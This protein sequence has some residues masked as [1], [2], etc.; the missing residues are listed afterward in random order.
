MLMPESASGSSS[1][2]DSH[3]HI[4]TVLT[5][6]L[7][8]Q[9]PVP[10]CTHHINTDSGCLSS[11]NYFFCVYSYC[12]WRAKSFS[13]FMIFW[14]WLMPVV[15]FFFHFFSV[16]ISFITFVYRLNLSLLYDHD[17]VRCFGTLRCSPVSE[18]KAIYLQLQ[19]PPLPDKRTQKTL[20]G[21]WPTNAQLSSVHMSMSQQGKKKKKQIVIIPGYCVAIFNVRLGDNH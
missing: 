8:I 19:E 9:L 2:S 21:F 7:S 15:L 14:C 11:A 18:K 5:R 17:L 10:S 6:L 12:I 20:S 13:L 1:P 4:P 16:W 3:H